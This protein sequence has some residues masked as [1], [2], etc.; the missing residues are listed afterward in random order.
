MD[1][2]TGKHY[3]HNYK[4]AIT[5]QNIEDGFIELQLDPARIQSVYGDMSGMQFTILK[6]ILRLGKAHKDKKQDLLDIIGAAQ[7]E[8][9][10]L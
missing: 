6:K 7:R 10:L 1:N 4:V 3:R 2:D 8:L 5:E 9:E